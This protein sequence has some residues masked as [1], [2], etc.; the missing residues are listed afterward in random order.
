MSQVST[1]T[2]PRMPALWDK[3][4]VLIT[5]K[6]VAGAL[7]HW[8]TQQSPYN[9]PANLADAV[10][11]FM[12]HWPVEDYARVD[13]RMLYEAIQTTI[14]KCPLIIAWNTP[15]IEGAVNPALGCAVVSRYEGIKPDFDFIDLGAL[16]RNITHE[17]VLWSQVESAQDATREEV[18]Q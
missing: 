15:K 17:L 9:A 1:M 6:S 10:I 16:A 8:A 5:R 2:I 3:G 11:E 12:G 14:G 7:A 4:D 13:S 18:T